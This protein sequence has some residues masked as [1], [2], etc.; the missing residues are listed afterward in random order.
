MTLA[1]CILGDAEEARRMLPHVPKKRR[2]EV[3]EQCTAKGIALGS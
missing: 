2:P 3:I 1:A